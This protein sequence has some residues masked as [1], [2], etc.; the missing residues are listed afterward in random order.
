MKHAF[1]FSGTMQELWIEPVALVPIGMPKAL[2]QP[3][4]FEPSARINGGVAINASRLKADLTYELVCDD[5]RTAVRDSLTEEEF[6]QIQEVFDRLDIN[7]DGTVS[8]KEFE[9]MVRARVLQRKEIIEQK[10]QDTISNTRLSEE[11]MFVA[12]EFK[13]Q[14]FQHLNESQS[15][16]IKMYEAADINGDGSLNFDEFLLAEAWWMHSTLNP[17]RAHLF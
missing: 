3:I 17:E 14:H 11:D 2:S 6:D 12:E 15:K 1:G 8:R 16:L 10:Y 13:R 7:G 5:F 4:K 9:A